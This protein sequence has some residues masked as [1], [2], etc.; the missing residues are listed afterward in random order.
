MLLVQEHEETAEQY[1]EKL[2]D[3]SSFV[4]WKMCKSLLSSQTQE[5]LQG[6]AHLL[7]VVILCIIKTE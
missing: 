3:L 5:P 6:T 1:T 7:L 2:N 4:L